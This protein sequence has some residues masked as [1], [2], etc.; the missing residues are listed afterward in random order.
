MM[1][2]DVGIEADTVINSTD[3]TPSLFRQGSRGICLM[4]I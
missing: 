2:M 1:G 3:D 4:Y